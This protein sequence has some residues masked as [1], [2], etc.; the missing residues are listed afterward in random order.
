[1]QKLCCQFGRPFIHCS[2]H[3]TISILQLTHCARIN[4][5][6]YHCVSFQKSNLKVIRRKNIIE[7]SPDNKYYFE[8]RNISVGIFIG[9]LYISIRIHSI[10]II[11]FISIAI[12][13]LRRRYI[14]IIFLSYEFIIRTSGYFAFV[15]IYYKW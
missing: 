12:I 4:Q 11:I 7:Y 15:T 1:M 10:E 5:K 3:P 14:K 8:M 13:G 6:A 2:I 9:K